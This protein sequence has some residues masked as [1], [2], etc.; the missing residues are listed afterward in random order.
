[1]GSLLPCS[2]GHSSFLTSP[3]W[4]HG[5]RTLF[6]PA[7]ARQANQRPPP[8][9]SF[10]HPTP[11]ARL[12]PLPSPCQCLFKLFGPWSF[13]V[14]CVIS[15]LLRL[16]T[17][18][19]GVD[20]AAQAAARQSS[21]AA[22]SSAPAHRCPRRGFR[23]SDGHAC[24]AAGKGSPLSKTHPPAFYCAVGGR[25]S[26]SS[27]V[28]FAYCCSLCAD[29]Q[30]HGGYFRTSPRVCVLFITK[31]QRVQVALACYAAKLARASRASTDCTLCCVACFDSTFI[32]RVST[33]ANGVKVALCLPPVSM[34]PL[35]LIVFVSLEAT[36][37]QKRPVI[38][39]RQV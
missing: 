23:R 12:P 18:H 31:Q 8:R 9:R 20:V 19:Q 30:R 33:H 6:A 26:A 35:C 28:T 38:T 16:C 15:R 14:V 39:R 21:A 2:C 17:A 11:A 37:T 13:V 7:R 27:A 29:G 4:S 25:C 5:L 3:Q 32:L 22:K 24:H 10:E 34:I 1:M 36:R